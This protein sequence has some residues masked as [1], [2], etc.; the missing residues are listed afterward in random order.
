MDT[1]RNQ[2]PQTTPEPPTWRDPSDDD[3]V[4]TIP[5][6]GAPAR[7]ATDSMARDP[8]VGT[9]VDGRY[10]IDGVLGQG[11]MGV[12]Y[13]AQ[14]TKIDKHVAIKIL[15]ADLIADAGLVKRFLNEARAASRIG[16]PHIVDVSDFGTLPNGATYFVMEHVDGQSLAVAML[17]RGAMSARELTHIAR[18]IAEALQAAHAV[19]VV[20]RDL[21]PDN[22]MLL[23]RGKDADFVKVLD[24]GIAKVSNQTKLTVAGDVF[25]TPHYMS[26]EQA[27]GKE[28]D[29]RTDIYS[30]GVIM[31][32]M[33][34]GRLPFE[35]ENAEILRQHLF[36]TPAPVRSVRADVPQSL[37][38]II[39][40][41]LEKKP[42]KRFSSMNDLIGDLD[43]TPIEVARAPETVAK[44][45]PIMVIAI[46]VLVLSAL[47]G[48]V[49][50]ALVRHMTA[51]TEGGGAALVPP[52]TTASPSPP[53]PGASAGATLSTPDLTAVIIVTVPADAWIRRGDIDVGQA[54]KE[55][56]F[57]KGES[58]P[59]TISRDGYLPR[60]IT[61]DGSK[62]RVIVQLKRFS[63]GAPVGAPPT[64]QPP[65]PPSPSAS[66]KPPT[67]SCK[68]GEAMVFGKCEHF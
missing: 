34:A 16:N 45:S 68:P 58:S 19:G 49:G 33:A 18:Q 28:V 42:G 43:G 26:P 47:I 61:V 63:T 32:E 66:A 57:A 40:K 44:R 4:A 50:Y 51:D 29:H 59:V 23:R 46:T 65:T 21:K 35:G 30:L 22:V 11:G 17:E 62:P 38:A 56:S 39:L 9:T 31:Y 60:T 54:P 15:R 14:H 13:R 53:A 12:V 41:C 37:D 20:H 7:P 24:F 2:A 64:A 52:L 27:G 55:L 3:S 5:K 6:Q 48:G 67:S 10:R 8:Y 1:P 36:V 25:G